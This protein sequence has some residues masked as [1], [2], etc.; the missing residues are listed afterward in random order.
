MNQYKLTDTF[1]SLAVENEF[2]ILL[3]KSS[4][5]L[6]Q[7]LRPF[8]FFANDIQKANGTVDIASIAGLNG[9]G[10]VAD[11]IAEFRKTIHSVDMSIIPYLNTVA[12][13]IKK[14]LLVFEYLMTISAC[15]IEI[16]K[17]ITK[18]GVS[19]HTYDK[20]IV[21]KNPQIARLWLNNGTTPE[22]ATA[23]WSTYSTMSRDNFVDNT[24]RYL[25]LETN[26]K[27]QHIGKPRVASKVQGMICVPLFMLDA[28]MQG[29]KPNLQ[30]GLVEFS[31]IKDNDT[32]RKLVTTLNVDIMR[33]FYPNQGYLS[34]LIGFT[35]FD[36]T[37]YCG[38]KL[39]SKIHRG[40]VRVPEIGSSIYDTGVRSLNLARLVSAKKISPNE[41]D[42]TFINVDLNSIELNFD[43]CLDYLIKTNA[44]LLPTVY[45]ALLKKKPSSVDVPVI[46]AQMTE[47]IKRNILLL[48]TSY[49]RDLHKFI[50]SH[51]EWFPLYTG[52]PAT[53]V[54]SSAMPTE[55]STDMLDF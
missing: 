54:V 51:P 11:E 14:K 8:C 32:V 7:Q 52:Q 45:E 22:Q 49:K 42:T 24:I 23:M 10:T 55:F 13:P 31:F 4:Y 39:S 6:G 53:N 26:T 29:I 43:N 35:D 20:Y 33:Q 40:Y 3:S 28:F 50:I 1:K 27:G 34:N 2:T 48:S 25:R 16:P 30:N 5:V 21:T 12:D 37:N 15:Y 44:S 46:K 41:V 9:K 19:T 36:S 47:E 38:L 18:E 17:W